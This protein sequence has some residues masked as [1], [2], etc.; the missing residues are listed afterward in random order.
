M[1]DKRTRELLL[2]NQMLLRAIYGQLSQVKN[3]TEPQYECVIC[4]RQFNKSEREEHAEHCFGFHPSMGEAVLET[5]YEQ[6]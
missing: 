5:K 3:N 1:S 4:N 6:I 2:T